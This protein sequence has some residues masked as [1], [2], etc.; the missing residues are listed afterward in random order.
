MRRNDSRPFACSASMIFR[1]SSSTR[2]AGVTAPRPGSAR[3]RAATAGPR[4]CATRGI[5]TTS[6]RIASINL[7]Y[8]AE[9]RNLGSPASGRGEGH[10]GTHAFAS[11]LRTARGGAPHRRAARHPPAELRG[12][13]AE[14]ATRAASSSSAPASPA[15][16]LAVGP[17]RLAHAR[18]AAATAPRIAIVGGGIA[19]LNAALDARGQGLSRSTIYEARP[20]RIGGRMHSDTSGYW[21]N[22]QVSEFCGELI[23]TGHKTIRALAQALQPPDRRP[24][25]GAAERHRRHVLVLRRRLSGRAGGRGLPAGPQDAEGAGQGDRLSDDC[26]TASPPPGQ[27]FDH[28]SVY[29]WIEAYVPGGHGS[30]IGRAARRRLQRGVR[31]RDEGPGVAQPHLSPRV[32]ADRAAFEIFG[33]SDER[34][35]IDG[36][37]QQLPRGDRELPRPAERSSWAGRCSRSGRTRDGTC[38]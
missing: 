26:T 2:R 13:R 6:L 37:N 30:R 31:R 20:T 9:M 33:V 27:Q 25:R 1:S 36:G 16:A 28:M 23:D 24:A 8:R 17:A 12:Q 11:R 22:G 18:A 7:T 38:R 5:R 15:P 3:W 35:H 14:A 34:F 21:A 19:G 10:D 32:P 4:S 29:D